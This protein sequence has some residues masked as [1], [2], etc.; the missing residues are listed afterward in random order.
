MNRTLVYVTHDQ[1]EAMSVA[2]RMCI[3]RDGGIAQI[4]TPQEIYNTPNSQYVAE[5]IGSPPINFIPCTRGEAG[6]GFVGDGIELGLAFATD[7][8]P[9]AM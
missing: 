7:A 3:M 2:D 4:G 5:V 9:A 1:E 6:G 8:P